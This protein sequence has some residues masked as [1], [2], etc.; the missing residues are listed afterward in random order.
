MLRTLVAACAFLCADIA[1]ASD[2][3]NIL[4]YAPPGAKVDRAGG[5]DA[6]EALANA[7]SA[8]NA[9]TAKGEPVCVYIPPGSYRIVTPP[10]PFVGAGC[11]MGDG[12]SQSTLVI[13]RRF[14]GDLFA[15]SEAWAV[16]KPGPMVVGVSIHGDKA[17]TAIQNAFVFYDRNDQ[18][19]IDNV[20]VLDLH[21]RA[22]L[23]GVARNVPQAY[24]RESHMR[25][26]RFFRDGAPG[27]PV[28]EFN[29]QGSGNIDATNEI[30]MSQ[31]DI[32]GSRGPSFVIR[33]NGSGAVRN[34]TIDALRIEGLE[35]GKVDAD[36]LTIGDPNMRGKVNNIT[37][38]NIELID[39][40]SGYAAV[41]LTA[42]PDAAAPYQ[43]TV[44]G[45]IGGGVPN[46]QGLRIDAGRASF[47]RFSGIHTTGTNVVIG[48]G[49]SQ[50]VLDG[51]G[52]EANWTYE[53]DPTSQKAL[54]IPVYRTGDPT[55][56]GIQ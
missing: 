20:D 27:V 4:D 45:F 13:D 40:Y 32:Y 3:L 43:I 30:R 49:V 9:K 26:L 19:F 41:R 42:P 25:S 23:S 5:A 53:I 12:P 48:R 44:Q 51:G 35:N 28:I 22:L 37:L 38:T 50:I 1:I 56:T 6:S 29:S 17:A 16:T 11:V 24:M 18:V 14:D 15:W 33:N 55:A 46:G 21:G 7:V 39:P 8:A 54:H 36:L 10:P 47:F 34:I 2:R 31:V 52:Q